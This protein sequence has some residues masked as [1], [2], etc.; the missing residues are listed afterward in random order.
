[1]TRRPALVRRAEQLL[2]RAVVSTAP[3]AGGDITTVTKLRLSDGTQAVIKTLGH[4][5]AG[6]FAAE[7]R[8]L[9]A[10]QAA[11]GVAVPELLAAQDDCVILRW[12]DPGRATSEGAEGLGRA[13]AQTHRSGAAT[14]GADADG[15][16]GRLPMPNRPL[17][18]WSEFYPARRLL[19]YLRLATDRGA[20]EAADAARVETVA[21]RI[22]DLVPEEPPA[23]LHGD[24]WNGNVLWDTQGTA[25]VID[26]ATYG[27]HREVDLAMLAL[28]GLPNLERVQAAYDAAY[29]LAEGWEERLG[30]HQLFPLLVHAVMFGGRYGARAAEVA[31]RYA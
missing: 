5:P 20:I 4:A 31:A 27:G 25:W 12:I 14:F 15:F 24:L 9:R 10:L 28:F 16:I 3:A 7:A 8:G 2:G 23:L 21:T 17:D 26:P 29:P 18:R 6:F 19:P 13:L 22:G 1:M 11:R 30:L